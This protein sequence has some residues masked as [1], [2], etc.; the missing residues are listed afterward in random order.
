MNQ[1]DKQREATKRAFVEALAEELASGRAP[2]VEGVAGRAGANKALV[3]RYFGGLPGLIAAYAG[4]ETF[5]PSAAELLDLGGVSGEASARERFAACV[6]ATVAALARRP[7]T[8]QVLLRLSTF[9]EAILAALRE[10]RARGVDEIRKAFG[11]PG[12]ELG[13]DADVAFSL[14]ISGACQILGARRTTWIEAERPVSELA[15]ELDRTIR[16]LLGVPC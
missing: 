11:E 3:Y 4:D 6:T 5:M 1:K 14:L 12:P 2:T 15:A 13:F 9:D 10:G 7:A 8:V 16:G